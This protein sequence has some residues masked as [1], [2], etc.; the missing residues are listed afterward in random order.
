MDVIGGRA[1]GPTM[2]S[3]F[4][5]IG[6]EIDT[7]PLLERLSA[8]GW[9]V[10]LPCVPGRDQ[11]LVF[12]RWR[13]GDDL[14]PGPMGTREPAPTAAAVTPEVL[15]VPLLAFDRR[16]YRLG[17]GGGYYDR[18]LATLGRDR[19]LA[20]GIAYADQEVANVPIAE[21]DQKVD[22]IVTEN[23][24]VELNDPDPTSTE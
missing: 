13:P 23:G 4:W 14:V 19:V 6:D 1:G 2:I 22:Y 15:I 7:R 8:D 18:T 10:A 11:H 21:T 16:G 9:T 3:V 20:V 17:Y 24:P 5:P 12:R